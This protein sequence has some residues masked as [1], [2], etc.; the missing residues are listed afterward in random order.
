[1]PKTHYIIPVFI[2]EMACPNRCV[3]CNQ[4]AITANC[5]SPTLTDI[6]LM[7][8]KRLAEIPDT[9]E[10]IE[11][12]FYGGN[13]TGI[14]EKAQR[15]YLQTASQ[16][17][18]NKSVQSIRISTR[19]DYINHANLEL[20]QK[21]EVKTI[22]L[23]VQSMN[24]S[25]LSKA[26]R[27]HT[28]QDT[29]NAAKLILSFGFRLGLQM[30]IGLPGDD[31]ETSLFTAT[32]IV[33]LQ[34]HET[35]IYPL[36]VIKNTV[37]HD[38]YLRKTYQPLSLDEAIMQTVEAV[39]EFEKANITILRIGLHPSKELVENDGLIAGPWHPAYKQLVYSKI[40]AEILHNILN[41]KFQTNTII[42]VASSQLSNAVGYKRSNILHAINR[43]IHFRINKH[44]KGLNY[45]CH[46]C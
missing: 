1:M 35:R 11:I 6:E 42:E 38:M 46:Y 13:F 43:N 28:A 22:E 19:P 40:W 21:F 18:K 44:L 39:K 2:P 23:G 7:V 27:G 26:Q 4:Y 16:F 17:L 14:N 33:R 34:A 30:M 10:H 3:Y 20:L 15:E 9:A 24:D 41:D 5:L 29:E 31:A 37:L 32:E 8:N 25:V 12:A 45:V 36:L